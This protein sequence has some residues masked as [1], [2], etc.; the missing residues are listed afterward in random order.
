MF[1]ALQ[2]GDMLVAVPALRALR[3]AWPDAHLTLV[4]LPWVR[5][6][7]QRLPWI[8]GFLAFPGHSGLPERTP[9]PGMLDTF[10]AA[11]RAL[12]LDLAVQ[13]HGSGEVT[14]GIVSR[15]GARRVAGFHPGDQPCPDP[16]WFIAWPQRGREAIR[17]L[18]LPLHLGAPHPG[19]ALEL[20]LYPEDDE[21]AQQLWIEAGGRPRDYICVHPGARWRSRRWPAG[22]FAAVARALQARGHPVVLTGSAGE[23]GALEAFRAALDVPVLDFSAR[24]TLGGLA[25]L[26]GGARLL[27]CNDTGVSHVADALRTP[28]VIVCSGADARR[29]QPADTRRHRLLYHDTPCRPCGHELCPTGH[30]CALGVS[31]NVVVDECLRLLAAE[32]LRHAA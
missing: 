26:V 28:S 31:V 14:N 23:A 6:L 1:R 29:W 16:R 12:R 24:T 27:V 20:A 21:A 8:D 3:A 4:G 2:L 30:E 11:V 13:L 5:E 18:Q 7:V 32:D 22:R 25:A 19:M 10:F 9:E 15:F 17:L